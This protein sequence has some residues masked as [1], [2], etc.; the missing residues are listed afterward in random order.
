MKIITYL[1]N[2]MNSEQ[3][4]VLTAFSNGLIGSGHDV[5]IHAHDDVEQ[6]DVAVVFSWNKPYHHEIG[7]C[8]GRVLVLNYG[9]FNRPTYYT[10]GWDDLGGRADYINSDSPSDRWDMMG[11]KLKPWKTEGDH[12]LLTCQVPTDGSVFGVDILKWSQ[13]TIDVL[14]QYTPYPIVFRP[15]PL[16]MDETPNMSG[17]TR[18]EGPFEDD[19]LNARALVTY[20]STSS[21]MAVFEGVP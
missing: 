3:I 20:N 12:I 19:L 16:A 8:A 6:C 13:D 17:A 4:Y 10:A 14:S 2:N 7:Q 9:L 1:P 15:H 5:L 18:S 21:S 11:K